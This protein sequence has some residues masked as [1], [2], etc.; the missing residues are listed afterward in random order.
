MHIITIANQK[1][2][3]G[4]TITAVNLAGALSASGKKVLF[5]DLD[6]QAHATAA[7]GV[8]AADSSVSSYAIFDAALKQ[9]SAN[10]SGLIQKRYENLWIIPSHISLSTMEPKMASA[11]DA[12]IIINKWLKD[13]STYDYVVIDTPPNLGFLTLNGLHTANRV[14]VPIDISIFSLKGVNYIKEILELS[15]TMGFER[16]KVNFVVT[17]FDGRSNFAKTFLE[18]AKKVLSKEMFTTVIRSTVKLRESA[19]AGKVIFEYA[20]SSNG[21]KDYT[22]LAKEILPSIGESALTMKEISVAAPQEA[23][24][25][26]KV[27]FKLLAPEAKTV[28]LAGNFNDWAIDNAALMKKLDNGTWIKILTLEPGDYSY[29]FVVDGKWIEDP[30]NT[31]TKENEYG[32]KDSLILVKS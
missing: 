31:L 8:R 27:I 30:N 21:S 12:T 24:H 7:F 19:Q 17:V 11:K 3:C 29:K 22:S 1:G 14:I 2:G 25:E 20:P 26:P 10:I 15:R 28:H 4:K 6:P 16:P 13:N 32:G 18:E 5:I 23:H 9:G